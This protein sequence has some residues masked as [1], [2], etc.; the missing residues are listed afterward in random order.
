MSVLVTGGGGLVGSHVIERLRARGHRVRTLVRDN[1]GRAAAQAQGA[2][3]VFGLV[4]QPASWEAAKGVDAIVHAAAIIQQSAWPAYHAVNV[5]GTRLAGEAAARHKA[6]LVHVSSVAVYR[7]SGHEGSATMD[8]DSPLRGNDP[9]D[10]YGRSK[11]LAEEALWSV[12]RASGASAVALRPCLIYGERDRVF[13]PKVLAAMRWGV[14]PIVGG[15][16]NT[17]AMVYAGNVADAVVAA[18]E[19]PTVQGPF[20][21]ANDGRLTQREFFDTVSRAAGR[22]LRY[23]HLSRGAARAAGMAWGVASSVV[24][25]S[26]YPGIPAAL[27]FLGRDNPYTSQRATDRLGWRPST[28]PAEGLE[29][30]MRWL[31]HEGDS[32]AA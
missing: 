31:T 4:E 13:L 23:L 8:E 3:P 14:A 17:L 10:N 19:N 1:A 15:G 2:E 21:V 28:T 22:R 5:E 24:G 12:M 27:Q 32:Q 11:A 20:N 7:R 26:A 18:L 16:D 9:S 25:R 30:A 6:R 29:R